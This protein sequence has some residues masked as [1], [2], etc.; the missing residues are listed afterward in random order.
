M[1][2]RWLMAGI[3]TISL[4]IFTGFLFTIRAQAGAVYVESRNKIAEQIL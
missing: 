4:E 3:P 1:V 2:D